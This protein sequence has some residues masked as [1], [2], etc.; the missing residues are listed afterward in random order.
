MAERSFVCKTR[1]LP[2]DAGYIEIGIEEI[3]CLDR[4]LPFT[5]RTDIEDFPRAYIVGVFGEEEG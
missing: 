2:H 4:L 3:L 5:G 1:A